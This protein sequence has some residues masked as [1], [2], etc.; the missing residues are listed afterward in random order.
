M[1]TDCLILGGGAAGLA[2]CARLAQTGARVTLVE[3]L[4]RVG[5]K[6]M[7]SGNGRCNLSNAD[8]NP[9]YYGNAAPFVERVYEQTPPEEVLAFF[10]SLGLMTA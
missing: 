3:R 8:M 10:S 6:I 9:A 5:K 1:H 4:D 2:A 7:A